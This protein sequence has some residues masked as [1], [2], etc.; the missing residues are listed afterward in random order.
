M[1][2]HILL[3]GWKE[4]RELNGLIPKYSELNGLILKEVRDLTILDQR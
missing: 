2:Q 1:D 3:D 4:V